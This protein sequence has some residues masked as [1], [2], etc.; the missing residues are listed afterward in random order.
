MEVLGSCEKEGSV[1]PHEHG[2]EGTKEVEERDGRGSPRVEESAQK[3][4][5]P[6]T[7]EELLQIIESQDHT[8]EVLKKEAEALKRGGGDPL[9]PGL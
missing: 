4:G 3:E 1:E 8:L 7:K 6:L 9:T 2:T 5:A